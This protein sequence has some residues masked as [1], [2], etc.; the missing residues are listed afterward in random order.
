MP[1]KPVKIS[2]PLDDVREIRGSI[3]SVKEA[4]EQVEEAHVRAHAVRTRHRFAPGGSD[5]VVARLNQATD[6]LAEARQC[7]A[8]ANFQLAELLREAGA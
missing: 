1:K 7:L 6:E 4:E 5:N 8:R 3:A 2:N